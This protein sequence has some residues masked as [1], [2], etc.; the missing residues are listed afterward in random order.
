M[1]NH[2]PIED[3]EN[4][5]D[6]IIQSPAVEGVVELIVCRPA[7]GERTQLESADL[8]LDLGLVGDNWKHRGYDK[9]KGSSANLDVQLNLMNSRTIRVIAKDQHR[10][11]LAGDQFFVDFDLTPDNVPPGTQ[12]ELGSAVIE[13]TAEP[14]LGCKK[15]AERFGMD[16]AKFVNSNIGKSLNLRGVNAKVISPGSVKTGDSI[17]KK[18]A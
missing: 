10:W 4:A 16:A 17:K 9:S 2:V 14:H 18:F 6:D 3:L 11:Q 15:F 8:D 7:V 12:L 13:V 1:S 5:L